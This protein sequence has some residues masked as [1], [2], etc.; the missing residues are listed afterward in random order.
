[1]KFIIACD[2]EGIHGV[3]G[4]PFLT[5]TESADYQAALEGALLE[6]DTAAKALYASFIASRSPGPGH[7]RSAGSAG[8]S[9]PIF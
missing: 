5:L 2:L 1:M 3:V 7:T 4:E 6:I 9:C 8:G